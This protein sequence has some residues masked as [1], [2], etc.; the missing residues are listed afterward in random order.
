M[1][2]VLS[3]F[4]EVRDPEDLEMQKRVFSFCIQYA[5]LK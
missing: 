2:F 5:P 1:T 4:V 3:Y